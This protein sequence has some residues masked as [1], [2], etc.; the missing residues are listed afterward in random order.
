ME[1]HVKLFIAVALF[2]LLFGCTLPVDNGQVNDTNKQATAN[3]SE[4]P[5]FESC[6][7]IGKEFQNASNSV[8]QYGAY[9]MI[10]SFGA[11]PMMA[12]SVMQ[13]SA[14]SPSQSPSYSNTNVQVQGIDESDFVKTDGKYI[15]A[16]SHNS[17]VI[18]EAYP[19]EEAKIL[20][21][22]DLGS[23]NT[24]EMFIQGNALIIFGTTSMNFPYPEP[25]PL[26]GQTTAQSGK[27]VSPEYYPYP[28][29][30]YRQFT[31]I[32][33]WDISDR[34]NPALERSV[35]FEGTFMAARLIGNYAY[36][37]VNSYPN[38]YARPMAEIGAESFTDSML[39][40]FRDRK[41]M[42]ANDTTATGFR[43]TAGCSDIGYLPPII[44]QGFVTIAS[45]SMD[46]FGSE[47]Q[48][49][50]IVAGGENVY[51]SFNSL[52]LAEV[53]YDYVNVPVVSDIIGSISKEETVVHRFALG[54]GKVEYS[55]NGKVPGHILNQFSMD[56]FE[57]NFRIAT[58]IGEVLDSGKPSTNNVYVLDKDL[59][60]AGRLEGLAPGEKI[61]SV[62]FMGKKAYVV[63]F[64]KV[65]PL[66]VIDLSSPE[67][68]KVL[69]KL[70]IP[71]Y[72]DYLHSFDEN[73]IIGVGKDTIEAEE[74]L[75]QQ[76]GLD[77]AWYQGVKLA[78]FD[79]SDVENPK[80]LHKIVI[81]DRG[82]D[83]YALQDHKA[84]LYD[85]QKE[86]L[87]LPIMLAEI[88]AEQKQ[89]PQ[90]WNPAYGN[91]T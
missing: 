59:N 45:V 70:K 79:V 80:E 23:Y 34:E 19:I 56:E 46:D 87:V 61:Y 32:Q 75:K 62:R 60:V 69:G 74:D 84:F 26:G 36:F 18:T 5:R 88:P 72:S 65:D 89:N 49:E 21:R 12:E 85:R 40:M 48:K 10:K 66:F 14:S 16:L 43:P 71:G 42:L 22:K 33:L 2:A 24:Q 11:L 4:M 41:G 8:Y 25:V 83:S 73:H 52:Y 67:K 47:I 29:Y 44:P 1:S 31:T 28:G 82:T 54:N 55:G 76:R 35:D 9:G 6:S 64:K 77:F 3:L 58:T 68:P 27:I 91:F 37:V 39:P 38:Y 63:T 90:S 57:G 50:T 86:L 30:S 15:Y 17:L 53:K 51:S 20:F 7:E 78:V 13:D 81:G